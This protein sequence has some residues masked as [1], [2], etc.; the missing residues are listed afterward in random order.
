MPED[1]ENN[2][3]AP[4]SAVEQDQ[5]ANEISSAR[6]LRQRQN[7][8]NEMEETTEPEP[9]GAL[10]RGE[11]DIDGEI[12]KLEQS[13]RPLQ[14]EIGDISGKLNTASR[15]A[16]FADT[17]ADL[18]KYFALVVGAWWT[19]VLIILLP[20]ILPLIFLLNYTGLKKGVATRAIQKLLEPQR[21][22]LN[23]KQSQFGAI[24]TRL[25]ELYQEKFSQS[26]S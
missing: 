19:I 17:L 8:N 14:K 2:E 18:G 26:N 15:G 23:E 9:Q 21:K 3:E 16:L 12:R 7:Q 24:Q 10:V 4:L 13:S 22:E 5:A 1:F 25:R 20:V 6:A 11:D